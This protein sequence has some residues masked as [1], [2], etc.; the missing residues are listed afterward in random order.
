MTLAHPH[1]ALGIRQPLVEQILRGTKKPE[2]RSRPTHGR[3]RV[4]ICASIRPGS[5]LATH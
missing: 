1:L 5:D 2:Y 4:L 3:G